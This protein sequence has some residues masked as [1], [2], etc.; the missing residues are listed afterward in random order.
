MADPGI[1]GRAPRAE[2]AI[3]GLLLVLTGCASGSFEDAGDFDAGGG[4]D[5]GA[6]DAGA[7]DAGALDAG[8]DAGP[9]EFFGTC[10][11]CTDH[12]E[13]GPGNFCVSLTIGGRACVPGC[14]PDVPTCPRAFSCVLDVA[15]GVDETVCLPIGGLCCVD[16]D[17]DGYGG[18]V[19]CLGPDCDD[20]VVSTH[21]DA[22][23][24]CNGVD[25][26]CDGVIDDPPTDCLSGRCRGVGD[27]T[28]SAIAGADCVMAMCASGTTTP[29]GQYTCSEGGAEGSMCATTCA[30]TGSD[31]DTF[32]IASAH[33]DTGVC[34]P[35][36]TNGNACDE[37]SDCTSLHCDNGYCCGVGTC[38]G[39]T[40]DCPG[41]GGVATL[42]D[43]P[44]TCQGTRGETACVA[45]QCRTMSGIADD[46]ACGTTTRALDCGLYDPVYCT[47]AT[48]QPTP[49]CPTSCTSDTDCV[50]SAHC[51]LGSCVP[52]RPLGA[53]CGRPDDCTSGLFCAD[54]V[55]CDTACT[56]VCQACN[57]P[58]S[59]GMCA[60][61]PAMMDPAA[62][63]AGF[64]CGS[65]YDGFSAGED[66]CY[67]RQ[68]VADA[69]A[70]CNG[71]GACI[72]AA[73]LCPLQ[74]RGPTYVDCNNTCESPVAG[75][76][77]GMTPGSCLDLDDPADQITCG[78]GACQRSAQRCMMGAPNACTPG[79]PSVE[80]C[81]GIDDDCNGIPD[82]G[83]AAALC[84]SAPFAASYLCTTMATCT[85]TCQTG[86]EDV[87]GT[88]MDGCECPSDTY[89]T[90][91][92]TASSLGNLT[93]GSNMTV[94]GVVWPPGAED[95]F[96]V[97]FPN[98]ARGPA[99]GHPLIRLTGPNASSFVIDVFNSCG[100]A[101]SCGSGMPTGV[102]TFEIQDNQS[103]PGLSQWSGPHSRAWP[104][105][106]LFRVR[107]VGGGSACS[108]VTYQVTLSR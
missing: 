84:P 72:G 36:L 100:S 28:Y 77:A 56:G 90:A 8:E 86:H 3:G 88:Y 65:Y 23:E 30:P 49:S 81:N 38:C 61:I 75:T 54:G 103:T 79:S 21:P 76:C 40:S 29:C 35:D 47:G 24:T 15:S 98:V 12:A 66:V 55:C 91:C 57:L 82:D 74:P 45:S 83:G 87:N 64:S 51:D 71:A 44:M 85:F 92:A 17:D 69:T 25:D 13:C 50:D 108:N 10:E 1:V 34:A 2:I 42:C 39:V 94:N 26:D 93:V 68:D 73:T 107:R 106:V 16:Q 9:S 60:P 63:C 89:S 7:M 19:G 95:W 33:C 20:G 14:V 11:A 59:L 46:S 104:S 6:M 62:E 43:T 4:M 5:A 37:D 18:G 67:R 58:T 31:D 101:M 105:T 80:T 70:A 48:D 97:G 53:T 52:D 78:M 99:N 96:S 102:G 41:G 22:D 27:G 32:C